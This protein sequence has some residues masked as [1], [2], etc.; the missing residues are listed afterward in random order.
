MNECFEMG[1]RRGMRKVAVSPHVLNT[2]L[3]GAFLGA[4][5]SRRPEDRLQYMAMGA[6]GGAI[7]GRH[8]ARGQ[9]AQFVG[10]Q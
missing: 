9:A 8:M 6:L 2:A 1:V 4:A 5:V 3:T 10:G 7:L